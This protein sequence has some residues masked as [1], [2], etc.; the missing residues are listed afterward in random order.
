MVVFDENLWVFLCCLFAEFVI[1]K[2]ADKQPSLYV[3][4]VKKLV[5]ISWPE[6]K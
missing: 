1:A 3:S 4:Q 5:I 6:A 2:T